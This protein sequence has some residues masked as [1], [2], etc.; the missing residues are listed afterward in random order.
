METLKY[1]C[2][3]VCYPPILRE[4]WTTVININLLTGINV[5]AVQW[6]RRFEWRWAVVIHKTNNQVRTCTYKIC[7]DSGMQY[8]LSKIMKEELCKHVE[9]Q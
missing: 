4:D 2:G 7:A 6:A 1:N 3:T 5:E 9:F 8:I